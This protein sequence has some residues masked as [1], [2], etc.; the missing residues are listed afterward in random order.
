MLVR[1]NNT[2]YLCS[3]RL[4]KHKESKDKQNFEAKNN[5]YP[6]TNSNRLNGG[7]FGQALGWSSKKNF[8]LNKRSQQGQ[9]FNILAIDNNATVIKKF[10]KQDNKDLSQVEIMLAIKKSTMPASA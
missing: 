9:S 3:H 1:K 4:L 5:H 6:I 8:C 7:L 2:S 10:K